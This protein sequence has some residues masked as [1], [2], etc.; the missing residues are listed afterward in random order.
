MFSIRTVRQGDLIAV[1]N[2]NGRVNIIDG[3]RRLFL[4]RKTCQRLERFSAGA[5]EYLVIHFA[6]GHSEHR[7]GPTPVWYDPVEHA[8][9]EI[10]KA[11][12]L[13][14]HE[15]VILYRRTSGQVEQRV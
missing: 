6:D 12:P 8:A 14:S 3:P 5:D 1:W 10:E 4:F 2:R 13:D 11:L 15:A 9:V 7:R